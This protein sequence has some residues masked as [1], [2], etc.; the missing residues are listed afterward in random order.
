MIKRVLTPLLVLLLSGCVTVHQTVLPEPDSQQTE[1]LLDYQVPAAKDGSL[2]RQ[3]HVLS[4]FQDRRAYRVG[5]ILTVVL[6][7]RTFS[8]K[9]AGT[10]LGKD[11]AV[12]ASGDFSI[13][14]NT[15]SGTFGIGAN[16]DFN[17]NGSSTQQNKLEGSITVSVY[18]VLPSG[19]LLIKG[20]KWL[21]LNQGD[22]FIKLQGIV[23]VEDIDGGNRLSSQRIAEARITYSGKGD[24]ANSNKQS[25]LSS[26]FNDPIFPI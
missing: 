25:W 9:Q 20:E 11:S 12:G 3:G 1:L 5:D 16:R 10:R 2:Y 18:K 23:R 13:G 21:R 22:E 17:G 6:D 24:I 7:E 19:V 15:G 8:S 26:F 4:L 14:G